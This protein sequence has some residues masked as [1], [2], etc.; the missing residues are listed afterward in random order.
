MGELFDYHMH[1][2]LC[3][4]G[5]GTAEEYVLAAIQG[6]L[7]E[8]GFAEHIPMYW[9][10]TAERDPEIAMPEER[11]AGYVR[12][13]LDLRDAYPEITIRLSV[14]ADY[15]PG[16]E[17]KL[18]SILAPYPW[19]YVYGSVHYVDGWGFDNP[20][21]K[22]RY[23]ELQIETLYERYFALVMGA[24]QSGLFD[25]MGHLDVI[26]KWGHR[27]ATPPLELY[28]TVASE[29]ARSG[30]VVEAN[31]AGYRKACAEL[32]PGPALLSELIVTGVPFTLGSDAHAPEDAGRDLS[33]AVR[34]LRAAGC[35]SLVRF[36]ARRRNVVP[37]PGA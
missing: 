13:V 4:H 21:Y 33:A 1:T 30:V 5:V 22:H 34:E 35:E 16:H 15:V 17:Q 28:R 7:M 24:A 10:P 26:K 29:L 27:P 3:G 25:V 12:T 32:Y 6:G 2:F 36:E 14:E 11:F 31:A 18:E 20:A 19:D 23:D 8:I 37:I 9:L